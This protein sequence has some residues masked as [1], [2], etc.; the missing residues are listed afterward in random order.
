M[1]YA[2]PG[3]TLAPPL[4]LAGLRPSAW[5]DLGLLG[6]RALWLADRN[7]ECPYLRRLCLGAPARSRQRRNSGRL[8]A[9][10]EYPDGLW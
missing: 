10:P 8:P 2:R 1:I 3:V 5:R 7:D 6:E 9:D 4:L